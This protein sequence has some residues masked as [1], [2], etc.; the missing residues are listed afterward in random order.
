MLKTRHFF[1]YSRAS[2]LVLRTSGYS[3]SVATSVALLG[4]ILL[5]KLCHVI[6]CRG[7]EQYL[8]FQTYFSFGFYF[9]VI[10]MSLQ[11][12]CLGLGF[13]GACRINNYNHVLTVCQSVSLAL[14][15][16]DAQ[17]RGWIYQN[18]SSR[19]WKRILHLLNILCCLKWLWKMSLF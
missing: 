9:V 4:V 19:N 13:L 6:S 14:S 1:L 10:D 8:L 5:G 11:V 3:N 12:L 15:V 17:N 16:N 18:L 7:N 2:A